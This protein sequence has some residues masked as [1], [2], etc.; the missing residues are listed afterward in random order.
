MCQS[1]W[2][3][4]TSVTSARAAATQRP[5]TAATATSR[6][7]PDTFVPG[8]GYTC[9]AQQV[10]PHARQVGHSAGSSAL[11]TLTEHWRVLYHI[12]QLKPIK[13]ISQC[14]T[15]FASLNFIL[16]IGFQLCHQWLFPLS[17]FVFRKAM[18]HHPLPVL[19]QLFHICIKCTIW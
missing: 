5:M 19:Y 17:H 4:W 1:K 16:L 7:V 8:V 15:N 10:W 6:P 11:V 18:R 2:L 12:S 13:K 9:T 3:S 14:F